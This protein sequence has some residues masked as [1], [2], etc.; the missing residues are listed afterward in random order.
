MS[1]KIKL[2]PIHNDGTVEY[3]EVLDILAN[4]TKLEILFAEG[5][6]QIDNV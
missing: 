3:M 5:W 4:Q 6:E 2:Q 1:N